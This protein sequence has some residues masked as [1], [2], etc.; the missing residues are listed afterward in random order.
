MMS[1]K[2]L[3]DLN[4]QP[5]AAIAETDAWPEQRGSLY[6]LVIEGFCRLIVLALGLFLGAV[7]AVI[8]SLFA[9]WIPIC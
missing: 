4:L 5:D 8:I 2:T 7:V 6:D 1:P 3:D 9:G